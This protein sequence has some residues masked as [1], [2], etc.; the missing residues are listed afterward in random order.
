M[1]DLDCCETVATVKFDRDIINALNREMIQELTET[2]SRVRDMSEVQALVLSS[3][4]DKFFSIGFDI[5]RLFE[6][7]KE[8]FREF[9]KTF[10]QACME[11]Y[12]FSKP[13]MAA[14]TGHAIA[15]G[16]ILALCCDYR[17]IASGRKLMG[18]NE[19]K[20]GVPVP[21]LADCILKSIVGLRE[22]R[23][24]MESGDFYEAE[25][26]LKKGLVDEVMPQEEVMERAGEKAEIL[27]SMPTGVYRRIKADRIR[28]IE[29]RIRAGWDEK[30]RHFI[31]VWYSEEA[32]RRLREAMEK[33]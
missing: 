6:L 21:Y 27:G 26:L 22:A 7:P 30:Q 16:C 29:T 28:E 33:F 10:N 17:V 4:N 31:D 18:L 20:L 19:I 13:T 15:G 11:L 12:T 14:I 24:V 2:L 3:A 9:Y 8:D 25:T 32:R 1:I 23:E 5:P